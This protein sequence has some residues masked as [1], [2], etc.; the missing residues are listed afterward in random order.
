MNEGQCDGQTCMCKKGYFGLWCQHKVYEFDSGDTFTEEIKL[1]PFQAFFFK[2]NY[3]KGEPGTTIEVKAT[4]KPT[5]ILGLN[6][7]D[8]VENKHFTEEL[9]QKESQTIIL[10]SWI[11]DQERKQFDQEKSNLLVQL[12]NMSPLQVNA[13]INI[14]RRAVSRRSAKYHFHHHHESA[15]GHAHQRHL[16]DPHHRHHRGHHQ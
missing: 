4:H 1:E 9:N 3:D 11:N 12:V 6:Q 7:R 13:K 14:S 10:N 8:E 2:E 16:P 5:M 15:H